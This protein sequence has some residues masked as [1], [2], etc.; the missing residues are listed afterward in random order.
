MKNRLFPHKDELILSTITA[1][2]IGGLIYQGF[3][4]LWNV[5]R[6]TIFQTTQ[7]QIDKK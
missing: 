5:Q 7:S 2:I 6:P 1:F 3:F 4:S